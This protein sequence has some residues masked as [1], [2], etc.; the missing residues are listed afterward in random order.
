MNKTH[1]DGTGVE[2]PEDSPTL[3][4]FGHQYSDEA[5]VI[6]EEYLQALNDLHSEMA[7]KFQA[8]VDSLRAKYHERLA[9]LPDEP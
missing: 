5:R 2:I 8:D 6:A 4:H 3:G 7:S 9:V 1:C